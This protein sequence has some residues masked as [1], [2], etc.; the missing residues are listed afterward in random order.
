MKSVEVYVATHKKIDLALP[1]HCKFIQVN[2]DK[3]GRWDGYLHDNDTTDNISDKNYSYCE[4]T[5]LYE[6]WKNSKA[7]IGGLF[8]YRRFFSGANEVSI[9]NVVDSIATRN[10][11]E[12]KI[13]TEERINE[14]LAKADIILGF[15]NA[16]LPLSA[17]EDLQKFVYI[18]DIW[19][20][21]ETV[22]DLFPLYKED[23]WNVLNKTG[24]SY[25]NMFIANRSFIDNYCDWLFFV[26]EKIEEKTDIS[27]YDISHQRIYGYLAEVL[28]NVYVLHNKLKV[29]YVY[30]VDLFEGDTIKLVKYRLR[31]AANKVLACFNI[32]PFVPNRDIHKAR[33]LLNRGDEKSLRIYEKTYNGIIKSIISYLRTVGVKQIV[34]EEKDLYYRITAKAIFASIVFFVLKDNECLETI[35]NIITK[36]RSQVIP[37]GS[38]VVYRILGETSIDGQIKDRLKKKCITVIE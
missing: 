27:K 1:K 29:A 26:L 37:F 33:Y 30:R 28:L 34:Q 21:I 15:P 7:K 12:N 3:M 5:A 24:I 23:L 22:E 18:E 4:L 20:M 9:K 25:C 16:P 10:Q 19:K 2:S 17:L 13:I 36:E 31:K 8:H 38:T 32:F 11:L 14:L 35:E 6:L